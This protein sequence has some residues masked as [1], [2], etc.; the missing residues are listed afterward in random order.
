MLTYEKCCILKEWKKNRLKALVVLYKTFMYFCFKENETTCIRGWKI[1]LFYRAEEFADCR[2]SREKKIVFRLKVT[3]RNIELTILCK[4]HH[5]PYNPHRGNRRE[6]GGIPTVRH[7][8]YPD[9]DLFTKNQRQ[10][11][12]LFKPLGLWAKCYIY[13]TCV[14]GASWINLKVIDPPPPLHV[15]IK[16][17]KFSV[18]SL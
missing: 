1:K 18:F 5:R 11:T 13:N 3:M 9:P 12:F 14:I 4:R 2:R 6:S 16:F 15:S 17:Q 8:I 7:Y 10:V